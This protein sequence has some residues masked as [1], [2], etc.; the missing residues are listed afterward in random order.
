MKNSFVIFCFACVCNVAAAKTIWVTNSGELIK[1]LNAAVAGDEVI[2]LPGQYNLGRFESRTGGTSKA[3]ITVK[4]TIPETVFIQAS[5]V[6]TFS[7][8]NPYWVFEN[9]TIRG[10]GGTHHAFHLSKNA[11]HV[12]IRNN[13][14]INFHSHIKSNGKG[15]QFP[16]FGLI[17]G[18]EMRNDAIR[19]TSE[20]TSPIDVVGGYGWIVRNNVVADFGRSSAKSV[21]YGIFLKGNSTN[22]LIEQNLV[23]CSQTHESGYRIGVS[24]GGGGTGKAYC[25]KQSCQ[26]EHRHG[27]IKNN[28]VLNCSDAG[29][30][31][32][33]ASDSKVF[34]NTLINTL[35]IDAQLAPTS[36]IV[37]NNYVGGVIHAR[38]GASI[39]RSNN[40]T[41]AWGWVPYAETIAKY[42]VRRVSDYHVKYPSIIKKWQ[43]EFAQEGMT[44]LGKWVADSPMGLGRS[45]AIDDFSNV[46]YGDLTP[47]SLSFLKTD[48]RINSVMKDFWG[49]LRGTDGAFIGAVDLLVSS[50]NVAQKI[51]DRVVTPNDKCQIEE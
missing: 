39:Q 28:V 8:Y 20:P 37:E 44:W 36:A 3:P 9:L 13:K 23:I 10:T 41:S 31:L 16:D 50:C 17:E 46:G 24:L 32:K 51:A 49:N 5:R 12:I 43:V 29:I 11:D 27:V 35:G 38:K 2:L 22:G 48:K 1:G 18:N 6:E 26:H 30:Y 15:D 45:R 7:I 34:H 33:K 25:E 40:I 21:S 4:A 14:L 19:Q 47:P 42:G